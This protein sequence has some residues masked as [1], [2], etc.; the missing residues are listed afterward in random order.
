MDIFFQVYSTH[1]RDLHYL[2]QDTIY[3]VYLDKEAAFD[4][5]SYISSVVFKGS[6]LSVDNVKI[7]GEID[8]NTPGT[9]Y[10]YYECTAENH[11]GKT[12]LTV[13]VR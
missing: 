7:T 6:A 9:Y 8:V 13:S 3:L 2:H 11:I 10:I 12:A 4:A 5:A 1:S